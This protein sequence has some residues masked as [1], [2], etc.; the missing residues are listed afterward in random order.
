VVGP[1]RFRDVAEARH[2]FYW[3]ARV[4]THRS[5]PEI[6][7]FINRDHATIMHGVRKVDQNLLA[8]MPKLRAV[9]NA[10]NVNLQDRKAA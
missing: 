4:Y 5:F 9:A 6:A 8:L 7:R 3:F 10:L 1:Y 2:I